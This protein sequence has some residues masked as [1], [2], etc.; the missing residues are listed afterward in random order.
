VKND[1]GQPLW[2][3]HNQALGFFA[4]NNKRC[5]YITGD[6]RQQYEGGGNYGPAY[7]QWTDSIELNCKYIPKASTPG[8]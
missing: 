2:R 8:K 4:E 7:Y 5:F 6:L 3:W 1:L